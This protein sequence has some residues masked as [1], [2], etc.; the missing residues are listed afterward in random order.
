MENF[1]TWKLTYTAELVSHSP[2]NVTLLAELIDSALRGEA[3]RIGYLV[4][5]SRTVLDGE[6]E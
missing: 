2:L 1:K 5:E 4:G 3:G 6:E